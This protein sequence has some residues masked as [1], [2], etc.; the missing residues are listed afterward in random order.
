VAKAQRRRVGRAVLRGQVLAYED[1]P[2]SGN[3]PLALLVHGVGS[4]RATWDSVLPFLTA[5]GV[6]VLT[7]D[8]PGH[9]GSTKGRGDYSLGALATS[10]RDLLDHLGYERCVLVGHSLGGGVAMQFAY[11]FPQRCEGLVLVASGGLGPETNTLLRAAS[12]PGA[13]LVI[14]WL[15]HPKT[16]GAI[17]RF[18][19]VLGALRIGPGL[20]SEDSMT[21]LAGLHDAPTRA[22]FLATLR[23]VVDISGQRVSAVS[24]LPDTR[25]PILLIWGDRDPV[26]PIA[27]GHAAVELLYDGRLIVFPGAGHEPHRNDPQRFADLVAEHLSRIVAAPA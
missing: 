4:S 19:T 24:R 9:G 6:H 15:S 2:G 13:E 12:L 3:G 21:I 5:N 8:L 20:L 18:G 26:I 1:I 7:V 17:G 25:I 22:A 27:H 10:L 11:Q 23:G 16:V 14:P